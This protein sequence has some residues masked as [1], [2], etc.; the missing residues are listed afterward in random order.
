MCIQTS[1]LKEAKA[2]ANLDT[3]FLGSYISTD[4]D[5]NNNN[6]KAIS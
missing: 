6:N 5:G 4:N 1:R 2:N 3:F